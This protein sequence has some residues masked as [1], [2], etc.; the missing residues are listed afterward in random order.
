MQRVKTWVAA[1]LRVQ[2]LQAMGVDKKKMEWEIG[3][4]LIGKAF[5]PVSLKRAPGSGGSEDS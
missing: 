2:S 3:I 5:V 4:P 1:V